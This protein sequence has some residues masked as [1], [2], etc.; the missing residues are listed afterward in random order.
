M[1]K[2]LLV[3]D[4]QTLI[5]MYQLKIKE[6]GLD[7]LL[8]PDGEIGL[9]LAKKE[10]PAVILLDIMMPKMDGFA[11]LTELKKDSKTKNIP[12]L[13]LTNLGQKADIEKGQKLGANDY[14]VKSSMTPSQVLEKIK[15][16]LK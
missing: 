13:L 12:V 9:E 1:A 14:I 16:F 10:L 11:V 5:E 8:A 2:I 4:D 3:E 7:L 6:G 15:S